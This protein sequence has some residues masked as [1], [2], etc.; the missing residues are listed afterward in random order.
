[1]RIKSPYEDSTLICGRT[2]NTIQPFLLFAEDNSDQ[3]LLLERACS[4]AGL[5][6]SNYFICRDGLQLITFLERT[7]P[8]IAKLPF[9]TRVVTDLNMPLLDGL[10]VLQWIREDRR[11]ANLPVTLMSSQFKPV[12]KQKAELL[13]ANEIAEKV[14]GFRRLINQIEL[15]T[16]GADGKREAHEIGGQ[17]GKRL[18][19]QCAKR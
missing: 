14:G 1:V 12:E 13:G 8:P 2:A 15:W 6:P 3:V 9:P 10:S 7:L 18:T 19:S 11:F 4:R 5:S 17:G 16:S